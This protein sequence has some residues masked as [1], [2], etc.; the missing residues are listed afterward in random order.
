MDL[1]IFSYEIN[2]SFYSMIITLNFN[3]NEIFNNIIIFE[4]YLAEMKLFNLREIK[5]LNFSESIFRSNIFTQSFCYY[6]K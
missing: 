5:L 2:R 4:S 6:L 1:K 3:E